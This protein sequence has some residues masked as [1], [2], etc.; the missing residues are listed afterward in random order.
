[1]SWR[2][3]GKSICSVCYTELTQETAKLP[4]GH[5]DFCVSCLKTWSSICNKCPLCMAE[6]NYI[7]NSL[8]KNLQ[9]VPNINKLAWDESYQDVLCEICNSGSNENQMLLCD[10]CDCGFH[11]YCLNLRR[12]PELE[13][14]FCSFCIQNTEKSV[15][16]RQKVEIAHC[17]ERGSGMA[18]RNRGLESRLTVRRSSRL[19][20][21][22]DI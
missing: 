20:V 5:E 22:S 14:W 1:M 21:N 15:Q 19:T 17:K 11:I 2:K 8:T 4:C 10:A 13:Y 3:T 16:T 6:F 12:L 7:E 9:R 18:L